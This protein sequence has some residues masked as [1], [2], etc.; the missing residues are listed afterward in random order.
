MAELISTYKCGSL[1]FICIFIAI[2]LELST[3]LLQKI[4]P[5]QL[6]FRWRRL[7]EISRIVVPGFN[8]LG[9]CRISIFWAAA[10]TAACGNMGIIWWCKPQRWEYLDL[11][12]ILNIYGHLI[13]RIYWI[14]GY[15]GHA[16]YRGGTRR[17]E[18]WDLIVSI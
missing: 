6:N 3:M 2:S 13:K 12:N 4:M 16:N 1:H 18:Y 8:L 14:W 17:L 5:R 15:H 10:S 11:I 9:L 7:F